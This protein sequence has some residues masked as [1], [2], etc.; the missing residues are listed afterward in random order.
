MRCGLIDERN[1]R[2]APARLWAK[3]MGWFAPEGAEMTC[4]DC[5]GFL[6]VN[7]L[8]WS[9]S[10]LQGFEACPSK[11]NATKVAKTHKEAPGP[12]IAR[13]NDFHR[14]F[15]KA[16]KRGTP[17]PPS[18]SK[19]Q[20]IVD[21]IRERS[22]TAETKLAL[23]SSLTP[24]TFFGSDSVWVRSI[25]DAQVRVGN[26]LLLY[27]WKTGSW[28]ED[29]YGQLQLVNACALLADETLERARSLF[30][31]LDADAKPDI[32][33]STIT[34]A[35]DTIIRFRPRLAKMAEAV[36]AGSW[37]ATPGWSCK[38]CPVTECRHNRS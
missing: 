27:D 37:P 34:D 12:A 29:A 25:A 10:A 23:T 26:A 20:G 18:M 24:T 38:Y 35:L 14:E 6:P 8:Q 13:G 31:W 4:P 9:W 22:G 15:E 17:L 28:K 3:A 30:I 2:G 33:D 1:G 11:H 19:W 36:E 7:R 5:A 21:G 32:C 16:I